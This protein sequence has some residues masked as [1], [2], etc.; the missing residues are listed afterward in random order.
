MPNKFGSLTRAITSYVKNH[1]EMRPNITL[2]NV[3]LYLLVEVVLNSLRISLFNYDLFCKPD[4]S[5]SKKMV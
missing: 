1:E 5:F 4:T 3:R 2:D